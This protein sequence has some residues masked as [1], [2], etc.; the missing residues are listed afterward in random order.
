VLD[1]AH[2]WPSNACSGACWRLPRDVELLDVAVREKMVG[3]LSLRA[4]LERQLTGDLVAGMVTR[5]GLVTLRT[6]VT[7]PASCSRP[8]HDQLSCLISLEQRRFSTCRVRTG[9]TWD[10]SSA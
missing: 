5:P 3:G 8:T 6:P 4:R 1:L 2:A 10:C 7:I 9:S